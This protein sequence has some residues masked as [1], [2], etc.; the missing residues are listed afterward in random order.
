MTTSKAGGGKGRSFI[1]A[2]CDACGKE[3]EKT[4]EWQHFCSTKCRRDSWKVDKLNAR[5][6]M[7]FDRRLSRI[8][9][10]LGL[11]IHTPLLSEPSPSKTPGVAPG[12]TRRGFVPGDRGAV[13][14][15]RQARAQSD[16]EVACANQEKGEAL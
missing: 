16:G 3:Y 4:R 7:E 9:A 5:R 6:L 15:P 2:H 12:T 10:H 13:G 1:L 8:E 11:S 14:S